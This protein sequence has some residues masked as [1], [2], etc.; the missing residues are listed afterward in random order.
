MAN[1]I[2]KKKECYFCANNIKEID[3][4]KTDDLK[5]FTN[6]YGQILSKKRTGV[7]A[8]HQRKLATAVKR[9]RIMAL[10][11]FTNR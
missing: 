3:Y 2:T 7:C 8:K 9:A 4:K 11:I 6:S 5:N 1:T 10:L